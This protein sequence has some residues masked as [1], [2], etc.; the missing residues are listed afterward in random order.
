MKSRRKNQRKYDSINNN[1]QSNENY[2]VYNNNITKKEKELLDKYKSIAGE[3]LE[4][5]E[6]IEMFTKNN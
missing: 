6:L 4:D 5:K 1:Y 3:Y 2:T